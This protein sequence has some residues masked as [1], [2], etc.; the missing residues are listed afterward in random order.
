MPGQSFTPNTPCDGQVSYAWVGGFVTVPADVGDFTWDVP[1]AS[2][3]IF[4]KRG[5]ITSTPLARKGEESPVGFAHS[6]YQLDVG[7][8]TGAYKTLTDAIIRWQGG[9]AEANFSSTLANSDLNACTATY[10][11]SGAATGDTDRVIG[12]PFSVLRLSSA[13][14]R[15]NTGSVTGVSIAVKPTLS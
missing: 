10:T 7:S 3:D 8:P 15:P 2:I 11:I 13:E 4:P 12:F 5:K 1:G 9:Y 14:Q 6:F